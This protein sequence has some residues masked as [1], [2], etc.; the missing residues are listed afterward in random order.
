[1]RREGEESFKFDTDFWEW[2]KNKIEYENEPLEF[3]IFSDGEIN[4]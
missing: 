3:E 2:F 4:S 1:L